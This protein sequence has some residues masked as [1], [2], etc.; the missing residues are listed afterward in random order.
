MTTGNQLFKLTATDAAANDRFGNSIAISGNTVIV[1]AYQDDDGGSQSG[2]AYVFDVTTGNQLFKLTAT[3]AT[4]SDL[5]G[6]SV[7]ISGNTAIVGAY[8][9]DDGATDSGSACFVSA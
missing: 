1:G 7:A 2:S 9:D 4:V 8:R 5:F 6:F 3:D